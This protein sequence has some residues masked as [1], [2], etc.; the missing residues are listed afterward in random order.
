MRVLWLLLLS[1]M[2]AF[3][4]PVHTVAQAP[5]EQQQYQPT[6]AEAILG[7]D[8]LSILADALIVRLKEGVFPDMLWSLQLRHCCCTINQSRC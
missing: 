6:V 5:Y 7:M 3:T 1:A 2:C 4:V 8:S